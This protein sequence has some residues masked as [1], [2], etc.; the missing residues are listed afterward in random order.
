M[1]DENIKNVLQQSSQA[2]Y[3][4][5]GKYPTFLRLP[6]NA[7]ND[8]RVVSLCQEAGFTLTMYNID[9]Q[10]YGFDMFGNTFNVTAGSITQPY[11]NVFTVINA[12]VGSFISVHRDTLPIYNDPGVIDSIANTLQ[13]YKYKAVNLSECLG[14]ITSNTPSTTTPRST[15]SP[16]TNIANR[17]K[18]WINI[19]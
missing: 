5:I 8:P 7:Y 19:F 13:Q 18:P 14:I 11:L 6:Y 2:V 17:L 16:E 9:S 15:N 1:S 10:D 3:S 12:G 4:Q